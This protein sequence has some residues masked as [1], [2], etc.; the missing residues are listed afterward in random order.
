MSVWSKYLDGLSTLLLFLHLLLLPPPPPILPPP[1]PSLWYIDTFSGLGLPVNCIS[2]QLAFYENGRLNSRPSSWRA[3]T[4]L[5]VQHIA[6]NMADMAALP[7]P[8]SPHR[9]MKTP[10]L[11]SRPQGVKYLTM[12]K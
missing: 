1:P 10:S 8:Y 2:R 6:Q 5:F 11:D 7:E 9:P 4:S 3:N 12:K